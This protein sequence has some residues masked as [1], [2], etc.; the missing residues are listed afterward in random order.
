[1]A[2]SEPATTIFSRLVFCSATVG[3]TVSLPSIS[4]TRT[5]AIGRVNGIF[6]I[7]SA[8]AAAVTPITSGSFS[9]SAESTMA[10]ICVSVDQPSGNSGRSGRSISR[11][12]KISR[13]EGRPSRLKNPPG[14]F[15]AEYV[16]SR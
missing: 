10:T 6:E 11:E 12:V 15:P 8:V 3:F 14:I 16:Y 5:H 13:S 4:P 9:L 2:S 1:M 7:Y